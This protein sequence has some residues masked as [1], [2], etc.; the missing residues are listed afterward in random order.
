MRW[1][2]DTVEDDIQYVLVGMKDTFSRIVHAA[3]AFPYDE[4][5]FNCYVSFRHSA[6][7][8]DAEGNPYTASFLLNVSQNMVEGIYPFISIRVDAGYYTKEG[9]NPVASI[10]HYPNRFTNEAWNS[11]KLGDDELGGILQTLLQENGL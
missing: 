5:K 10:N 11:G 8:K 4:I 2:Y 1:D 6:Y 3:Q 9:S 7:I